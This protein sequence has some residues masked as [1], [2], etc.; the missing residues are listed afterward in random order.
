MS[1]VETVASVLWEWRTSYLRWKGY[2]TRVSHHGVTPTVRIT[3]CAPTV[4]PS[5][6]WRSVAASMT[7][8]T[9][10]LCATWSM[11]V[12]VQHMLKT[13]AAARTQRQTV[14]GRAGSVRRRA[15]IH[16]RASP[17]RPTRSAASDGG[18]KA[19]S[20]WSSKLP[21]RIVTGSKR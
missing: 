14:R 18:M 17:P 9:L 10:P 6:E 8:P 16:H 1:A 15:W 20:H 21:T 7:L 12:G 13:T 5:G 3:A 2:P 4:G 11:N 19:S